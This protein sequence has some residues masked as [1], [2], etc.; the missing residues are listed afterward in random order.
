MFCAC[1]LHEARGTER[2]ADA[3]KILPCFGEC[4]KFEVLCV[5][6]GQKK[7]GRIADSPAE[8]AYGKSVRMNAFAIAAMRPAYRR[9]ATAGRRNEKRLQQNAGG[10]RRNGDG[11]SADLAGISRHAELVGFARDGGITVRC[12]L[13]FVRVDDDDGCCAIECAREGKDAVFGLDV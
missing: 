2:R 10:H 4:A 3:A 8:A 7:A 6:K 11:G 13:G 5:G 12:A 9:K 1:S